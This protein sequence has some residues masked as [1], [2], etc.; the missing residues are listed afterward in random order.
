MLDSNA[1][2]PI[3]QMNP[4]VLAR[5]GATVIKSDNDFDLV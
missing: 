4:S 3:I 5:R 1:L 2:L